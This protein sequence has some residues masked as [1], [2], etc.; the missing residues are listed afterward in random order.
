MKLTPNFSREE[1]ACHCGCGMDTV[2]VQL[3]QA[4]SLLRAHFDR[5]VHIS[6]GFRCYK[7]NKSIGGAEDSFHTHGKAADIWVKDYMPREV[8]RFLDKTFPDRYGIGLY[9]THV[10]ID[11]RAGKARW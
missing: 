3:M 4:L 9:N 10:H 6:S 11:V 1:F 5:P 2:D 7:H 8:Y